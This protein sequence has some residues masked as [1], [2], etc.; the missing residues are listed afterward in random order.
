MFKKPISQEEAN[1]YKAKAEGQAVLVDAW[2][3]VIRIVTVYILWVLDV[4][5]GV[6]LKALLKLVSL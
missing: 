5:I 2:M 1:A 6:D 4:K 3:P